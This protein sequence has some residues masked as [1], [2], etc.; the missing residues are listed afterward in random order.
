MCRSWSWLS[1][2]ARSWMN[3]TYWPLGRA[4]EWA[5]GRPSGVDARRRATRVAYF[6]AAGVEQRQV[7]D[8]VVMA[9]NGS[10]LRDRCELYLEATS[11]V[12]RTPLTRSV[13]SRAHSIGTVTGVFDE[14]L[15][16]FK[17]PFVVSVVSQ[18]FYETDRSRGFADSYMTQHVR[19]DSTLGTTLGGYLAPVPWGSHHH[20]L[21]KRL[22]HAAS[23]TVTTEDPPGGAPEAGDAS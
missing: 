10:G 17:G 16:G 19:S 18:E 9:A 15:E 14:N 5:R 2:G 20:T 13:E 7:A 4:C 11:A 23:V 12:W 3:I 8:V 22:G 6:D 21:I 1:A